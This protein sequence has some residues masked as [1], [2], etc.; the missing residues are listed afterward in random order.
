MIGGAA[1]AGADIPSLKTKGEVLQILHDGYRQQ[2]PWIVSPDVAVDTIV[3][4]AMNVTLISPVD[5]LKINTGA[6]WS[7]TDVAVITEK[8]D[9]ALTRIVRRPADVYT[10]PDQN[11]G[12]KLPGNRITRRQARFDLDALMNA[13][14]EIHPDIYSVCGQEKLLTRFNEVRESLP[15]TLTTV[16]FYKAAAPLVS[17]IGDGHT[18]LRFP[19]NDVFT[20]ELLRL[21]LFVDVKSDRTLKA[22]TCIDSIVPAGAD[23]LSIN[24]KSAG[25]MIE[26]MLPYVSGE[27]DFYKVMRL[28]NEFAALF[29]M[30][31]GGQDSYEVEFTAPGKKKV[32]N[33][34]LPASRFRDLA[35]RCPKRKSPVP[36][37]DY[38]YTIDANRGVAVMDF[39]RFHGSPRQMTQFCDSMFA[40]MK[41]RG[42]DRLIIDVRNNGGGNS[43][44][45]DVLL[46]Y[47]SPVPFTQFSL[48]LVNCSARVLRMTGNSDFHPAV[49]LY[50]TS[51]NNYIMPLD[52][53]KGHFDGK[54]ILLTSNHTF[55][56]A[57]AFS[58]AFKHFGCGRVVGEESGGMNVAYGDI[59]TWFA[60]VSG[61]A[62]TISWKRFWHPGADETDIH[63]TLP[64]VKTTADEALST[65]LNMMTTL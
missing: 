50:R 28:D 14:R 40:D 17:M 35:E 9:T 39:R 56:S 49:K 46:R 24:G 16:E 10:Y 53:D 42:I 32:E 1:Q 18:M 31:Y 34:V 61:L 8:G 36:K 60:P 7:A 26:E 5:T 21:P 54:V 2:F 48:T 19:Y 12:G 4:T 62:C 47:I 23:I 3:T 65:A 63:G 20:Q 38:S 64:D 55:S 43:A 22:A 29:E 37:A 59:L 27:R 58:W 30:L 45:G 57:A 33:A 15:D 13:L 11:I 51:A 52:A 6:E 41:A 25:R 44:I